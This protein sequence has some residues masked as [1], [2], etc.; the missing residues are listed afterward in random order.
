MTYEVANIQKLQARITSPPLGAG[1]IDGYSAVP[2]G[3]E[4][5]GKNSKAERLGVRI[6]IDVRGELLE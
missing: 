3:Q 1:E 6:H 2:E 5:D 4:R